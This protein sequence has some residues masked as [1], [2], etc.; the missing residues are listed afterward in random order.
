MRFHRLFLAFI[1]QKEAS[2]LEPVRIFMSIVVLYFY[3]SFLVIIV[4]C[5]NSN[6]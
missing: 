5:F 4:V 3:K 6:P 1:S 2:L